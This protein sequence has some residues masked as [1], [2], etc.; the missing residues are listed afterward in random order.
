ML[1]YTFAII[2][3][4][5]ISMKFERHVNTIHAKLKYLKTHFNYGIVINVDNKKK[6]CV[7]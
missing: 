7:S 4:P 5:I 1:I 3:H 2:I 6:E